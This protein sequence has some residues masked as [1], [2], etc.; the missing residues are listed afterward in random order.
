MTKENLIDDSDNFKKKEID[1]DELDDLDENFFGSTNE[2][3]EAKIQ[4]QNNE[5]DKK[6]LENCEEEDCDEED[7]DEE[8]FDDK[9][10]EEE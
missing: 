1:E 8:Y 9:E 5:S 10:D 4:T 6:D 7:F 3:K 2:I